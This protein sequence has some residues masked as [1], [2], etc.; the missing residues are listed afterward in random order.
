MLPIKISKLPA[1]YVFDLQ[2]HK[3]LFPSWHMNNGGFVN[4]KGTVIIKVQCI[5]APLINKFIVYIVK[6]TNEHIVQSRD[7]LEVSNIF[8]CFHGN[9]YN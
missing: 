8:Q 1:I 4:M 7:M 5:I 3:P 6:E 2:Q 9:K